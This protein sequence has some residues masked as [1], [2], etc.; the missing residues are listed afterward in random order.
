MST[1]VLLRHGQSAWNEKNLFTGWVDVDL[2]PLGEHEAKAAGELLKEQALLP[3][4]LYTSVLR[5]AI[6]TAELT[7]AECNRSWIRVERS[8]RL[9]ERHYGALQG[10]D[11][12]AT[13][14]KY[15]ADQLKIWRRSYDVRPPPAIP[16]SEWVNS[17]D[18]RYP[19]NEVIPDS[20]CLA[21]VVDRM[22]PYWYDAIGPDLL[23]GEVVL[24]V[25]HGNSLRALVKH[26][27]HISDVDIAELNIPTG[28]PRVYELDDELQVKSARYLGDPESV[29]AKAQAVAAQAGG[30]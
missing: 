7:L 24:V 18:P 29:A 27:E 10:L 9:N 13:R 26:L 14:E 28:M 15:G 8:W 6:H 1:L 20:E 30:G 23:R 19:S 11:K 25:A 2:T 21:D 5:R 12:G 22:M 3:S 16:G 4:V 17:G